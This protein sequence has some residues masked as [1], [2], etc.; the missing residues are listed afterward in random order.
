[1]FTIVPLPAF[2][3]SGAA[4]CITRKV[5]VRFTATVRENTSAVVSAIPVSARMPAALMTPSSPPITSAALLTAALT[6]AG[7]DT[8]Q[9]IA[10]APISS[11]TAFAALS[12]RSRIATAAPSRR[13]SRAVAR[14]IPDA[15]PVMMILRPASRAI[16]VFL[17]DLVR[18]L[19][20]ANIQESGVFHSDAITVRWQR[21]SEPVPVGRFGSS[22]A[23]SASP[24]SARVGLSASSGGV[25]LGGERQDRF[26][27]P[28]APIAPA[29]PLAPQKA[30]TA[31]GAG[32]ERAMELWQLEAT[33]LARLIRVG[34]ASSRE[35]VAACLARMDAVNDKLNAVVRRMDEEALVAA[36][37]ADAARAQGNAL[38]PLHGVPVTIKVNTRKRP[39]TAVAWKA[40]RAARVSSAR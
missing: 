24:S 1:M 35:A 39:L 25:P 21:A 15:P 32:R 4:A 11:A 27:C 18:A 10:T 28:P 3:I 12:D 31:M 20:P 40:R 13:N 36:D 30:S 8:S 7:S 34:Q 22:I 16:V 6:E 2:W 19:S 38:G 14:P 5:P 17:F 26:F 37:A 33:E 29:Q 9:A 23:I